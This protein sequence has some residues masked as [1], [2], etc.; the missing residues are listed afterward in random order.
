MVVV[1]LVGGFDRVTSQVV[2]SPC[3]WVQNIRQPSWRNA[4]SSAGGGDAVAGAALE[5]LEAFGEVCRFRLDGRP[6]A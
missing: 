3:C 2:S 6:L 4:E 5:D 1:A